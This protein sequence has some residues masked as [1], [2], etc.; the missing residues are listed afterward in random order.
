MS[1]SCEFT[2]LLYASA[3]IPLGL[4]YPPLHMQPRDGAGGEEVGG[5]VGI[6]EKEV[7]ARGSAQEHE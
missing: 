6:G 5:D 2:R 3:S 1:L 7:R 4:G